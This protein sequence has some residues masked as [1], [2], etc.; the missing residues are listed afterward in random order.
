MGDTANEAQRIELI[1]P[2][3]TPPGAVV[4]ETPRAQPRQGP[5]QVAIVSQHP[6]PHSSRAPT[7]IVRQRGQGG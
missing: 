5:G 3:V 1:L 2:P 4:I 7:R 6:E